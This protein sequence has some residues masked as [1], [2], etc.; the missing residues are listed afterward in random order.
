MSAARWRWQRAGGHLEWLCRTG[1]GRRAGGARSACSG[2]SRRCSPRPPRPCPEG[3][4]LDVGCGT[5]AT[6]P[7]DRARRLG[8]NGRARRSR[9]LGTDARARRAR[10]TARAGAVANVH[11]RRRAGPIRFEPASVDTIVSRFGVM[12]FA[13][14]VAAFTNLRRA[15]RSDGALRVIAWRSPAENPFMTTA[16]RAAAPLLPGLPPRQQGGPGQF[17]FADRQ[18]VERILQQSGWAGIEIEPIDVAARC[19][20]ETNCSGT[21]GGS[22]RSA[23]FC[24]RLTRAFEPECLRLSAPRS[25]RYVH[26]S[27]ARFNAACWMIR[28]RSP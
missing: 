3:R 14:P 7:S 12:F 26:G 13:N 19:P 8:P 23:G 16:E 17:A 20:R 6:R 18:Y 4:V 10:A 11:Q 27:E 24:P 1:L 22:V 15:V 5:G 21:S 28:A 9:Y 2:P 25:I